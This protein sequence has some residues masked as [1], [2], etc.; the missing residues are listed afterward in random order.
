MGKKTNAKRPFFGKNGQVIGDKVV[1]NASSIAYSPADYHSILSAYSLELSPAAVSEK[2][3]H[4]SYVIVKDDNFF[5]VSDQLHYP[6]FA[7]TVSQFL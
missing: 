2:L 7:R 4:F 1:F 6:V 5:I 3:V